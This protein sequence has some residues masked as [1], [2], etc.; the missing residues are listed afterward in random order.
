ME[1]K[2]TQ[3]GNSIT[4]APIGDLDANSSMM[5]DDSIQ[6]GIDRGI[7][8]FHINCKQLDYISSA[9][10][11]VFISFIDI[12]QAHDGKFVFSEMDQ[13]VLKVFQ[14]LG[15]DQLMTIVNDA[16]EADR[17]LSL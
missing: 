17:A 12:L 10:L 11:G 9:G 13:N 6:A 5:M 1:I 7:Y 15:L 3:K 2:E 16:A 4:L 14:L 8:N